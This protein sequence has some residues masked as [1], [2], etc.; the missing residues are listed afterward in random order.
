MTESVLPAAGPK[1]RRTF[2][3]IA[4]LL[5]F[6]FALAVAAVA[7]VPWAASSEFV[8]TRV[9]G[10][11]EE[12]IGAPVAIER[13][14]F[15]W[16]GQFEVDGLGVGTADGDGRSAAVPIIRWK[17]AA[18]SVDPWSLLDSR[19]D[20]KFVLEGAVV[21]VPEI[22]PEE[23]GGSPESEPSA[24]EGPDDLLTQLD[25]T[26]LDVELRDV[27]VEIVRADG[28]IVE[29]LDLA[30]LTV[31]KPFGNA[32]L[33]AA[34]DGRVRGPGAPLRVDL[35]MAP[36]LVGDVE[37]SLRCEDLDLGQWRPLIERWLPAGSIDALQGVVAADLRV[38]GN[39]AGSLETEGYLSI[40]DPRVSGPM[41]SGLDFAV[42]AL[43]L[44]PV[45]TLT[46]G[47]DGDLTVDTSRVR[48]DAGVLTAEGRPAPGG[49]FGLAFTADVAAIA[50]MGG[51]M[52]PSLRGAGNAARGVIELDLAGAGS[53]AFAWSELDVDFVT[54]DQG[55]R[56]L[57]R[58]G[59]GTFRASPDGRIQ[60][61]ASGEIRA[62]EAA[63]GGK[64]EL[65]ADAAPDLA[66]VSTARLRLDDWDFAGQR[67]LLDRL[68]SGQRVER[69]EGV[70]SADLTVERDADGDLTVGGEL[71]V[72]D[73]AVAG[74]ALLGMDVRG[75]R[76]RVVPDVELAVESD[77]S[78]TI[79]RIVGASIDLGFLSLRGAPSQPGHLGIEFWC[80]GDRVLEMGAP[81]PP[82]LADS[83]LRVAGTID[84]PAELDPGTLLQSVRADCEVLADR[85]AAGGQDFAGLRAGLGL[86]AGNVSIELRQGTWNGGPLRL[87]AEGP[88][89]FAVPPVVRVSLGAEGAA[90]GPS[91]LPALEYVVPTFA[92]LGTAFAR[93][94]PVTFASS[95]GFSM[96]LEGPAF[97]AD[98]EPT[99]A[100]LDHWVGRGTVGLADGRF[101]PSAGLKGLLELTG[102]S[103]VVA[104]DEIASAFE[105]AEGS[106]RTGL[107]KMSAKGAEYGFRGETRLDGTLAHSFDA[108]ALLMRHGDGRKILE[109]L[110]DA[111]VEARL[112]GTLASP[113][114]ALPDV[115]ELA[116]RAAGSALEK[117]AQDLLDKVLGPQKGK[118]EEAKKGAIDLL[119]GILG[120]K[121]KGG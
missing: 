94:L 81:L 65:V 14:G 110:G 107:S 74:P 22:L 39:L 119:R 76:F 35:R 69:L 38:R 5:G 72:S 71:L 25:R 103:G 7:S 97:P 37:G 84:V 4:Q 121:K 23:R 87:T 27:R 78:V 17:H 106:V 20:L 67:V 96:E 90:V 10:G 3:R 60:I 1:P 40:A 104:F 29:A 77:G 112:E 73:A 54:L 89:D 102:Q 51:P 24:D 99:L 26:R 100:W 63:S 61:E 98:G 11:L 33:V 93:G 105:F 32:P 75:E 101:S 57:L 91:V 21:Q 44:E 79:R 118:G 6:G 58:G 80:D 56:E 47:P 85:I 109:Y 86:E 28:S 108:R 62:A 36:S 42:P 48:L 15:S 115:T 55:V 31:E 59:I 83:G 114:L 52:P 117:G 34:L 45:C 95:L 30:Q 18:A 66:G 41:L 19:L 68:V 13:L 113:E 12:A 50:S 88:L 16:S 53:P 46:R 9:A 116:S 2:R 92:G 43:R 8:R 111:P 49:R 120:G 64:F 82:E 70:V